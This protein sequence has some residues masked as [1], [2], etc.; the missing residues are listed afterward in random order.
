MIMVNILI[1]CT[2][3]VASIKISDLVCVLKQRL[4]QVNVQIVATEKAKHFLNFTDQS[5]QVNNTTM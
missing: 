3:S 5:I 2:G 1:G 4:N